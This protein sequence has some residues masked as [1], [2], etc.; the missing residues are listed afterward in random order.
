MTPSTPTGADP[1]QP[2]WKAFLKAIAFAAAAAAVQ[3]TGTMLSGDPSH[4][5][6]WSAVGATAG[7]SAAIG[8]LGYVIR[9]PFA[10]QNLRTDS[11]EARLP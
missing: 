1:K 2:K 3:T 6:S 11:E 8:A 10:T 5:P 9:S 4:P 7:I